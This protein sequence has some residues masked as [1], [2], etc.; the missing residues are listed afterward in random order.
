[1]LITDILA[2][3]DY[4]GRLDTPLPTAWSGITGL[5]HRVKTHHDS[6]SRCGHRTVDTRRL[7]YNCVQNTAPDIEIKR[8]KFRVE[9]DFASLPKA[10]TDAATT[11]AP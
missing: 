2:L 3:K 5:T 11:N 8:G 7:L 1:M 9:P 6:T 4:P 10:M